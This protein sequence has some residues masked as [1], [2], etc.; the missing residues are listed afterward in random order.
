[1]SPGSRTSPFTRGKCPPPNLTRD[2]EAT[3]VT[4]HCH[5]ESSAQLITT[6]CNIVSVLLL[7]HLDL[8]IKSNRPT[9]P[10]GFEIN[11]SAK[12]EINH[13]ELCSLFFLQPC[14]WGR[15]VGVGG[16]HT[17]LWDQRH[18]RSLTRN[19]P[20][21]SKASKERGRERVKRHSG[22]G[23]GGEEVSRKPS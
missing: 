20:L 4:L 8:L 16:P 21:L 10:C 13:S 7:I 14:L 5:P 23:R 17:R 9:L 11:I 2:Q 22:T 15:G 1:M 3:S 18:G 19:W 12:R 6:N